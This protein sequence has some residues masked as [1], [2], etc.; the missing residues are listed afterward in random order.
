[1]SK[2]TL[3]EVQDFEIEIYPNPTVAL[4][5]GVVIDCNKKFLEL[6]PSSHSNPMQ[7]HLKS[8]GI[9]LGSQIPDEL[10]QKL[11]HSEQFS[12][13]E[14]KLWNNSTYFVS[15]SYFKLKGKAISALSFNKFTLPSK[16]AT[17]VIW[18]HGTLLKEMFDNFSSW[19]CIRD[20]N[21]TI[22]LCNKG[23]ERFIGKP[24][25]EIVGKH[26]TEILYSKEEASFLLE[27]D[28]KLFEGKETQLHFHHKFIDSKGNPHYLEI[29]RALINIDGQDYVLCASIDTTELDSLREL[30][31]E[32]TTLYKTLIENAFDAIYLMKGRRYVYVNPRFCELTGYTFEELTAESFDFGVLIPEESKKYLEER[33]QA[34]LEGK[35]IPNQ[36]ELQLLHKDGR[37]VYVEVS[38]VSVGK[39]GEVVVMGIMRDITQRKEYESQLRQS[40]SQLK[41]LNF[42]KDKFF[43]IIAHD[44]RTP[45]SGLIS[46]NKALIENHEVLSPQETYELLTEILDYANQSFNLLENLLQWSRTQTGSIPFKPELCDIFEITQASKIIN[47]PNAKRKQINIENLVPQGSYSLLDRNMITAVFRNLMSNAVKYTNPGGKIQISLKENGNTYEI[48]VSDNGV[49]MSELQIARLFKIGEYVST[50]GTGNEKGSGLGLILCKEFVEKNQGSLNVQSELGKGSTFVVT[51]PKA[52]QPL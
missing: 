37:K 35:E 28:K 42:A 38:T 21:G 36:Y 23:F 3:V 48:A 5:N 41:E 22:V 46:M 13:L 30:Y 17:P 33:Y 51:L 6:L 25:E 52:A 1:M 20:R 26:L 49:G 12:N 16:Y 11:E 15:V 19:V 50:I 9:F 14:V 4:E 34:R 29:T 39:P 2:E 43:N 47:E 8:I 44:L 10:F 32:K 7:K 27:P 40:E 45:I 18:G 31:E 24:Y